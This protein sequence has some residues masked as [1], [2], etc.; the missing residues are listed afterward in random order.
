MHMSVDY[1]QAKDTVTQV[2]D[3]GFPNIS[4]C[5]KVETNQIVNKAGKSPYDEP[6][7]KQRLMQYM[8]DNNLVILQVPCKQNAQV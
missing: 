8:N 4:V 7:L 3:T 1:R 5:F 6:E 2:I